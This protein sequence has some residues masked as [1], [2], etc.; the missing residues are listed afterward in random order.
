M[1]NVGTVNALD[2]AAMSNILITKISMA[3][4]RDFGTFASATILEIQ[5]GSW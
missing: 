3:T 4:T 5:N 2:A 1:R